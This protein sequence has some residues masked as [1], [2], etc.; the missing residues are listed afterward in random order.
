MFDQPTTI[1]NIII[2]MLSP[3]MLTQRRREKSLSQ[4]FIAFP[5]K[6]NPKQYWMASFCSLFLSSSSGDWAWSPNLNGHNVPTQNSFHCFPS[7]IVFVGFCY[8]PPI[9]RIPSILLY[10]LCEL[11]WAR[12]AHKNCVFCSR[13]VISF[14]LVV[15]ESLFE[16]FA[17]STAPKSWTYF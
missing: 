12:E 10:S 8:S 5:K 4:I 11:L 17:A 6:P 15:I 3:L 13:N 16:Y 14:L 7:H 9:H 2:T 1:I